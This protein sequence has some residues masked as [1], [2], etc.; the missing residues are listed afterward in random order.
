VI[1][2]VRVIILTEEKPAKAEMIDRL[3]AN[4]IRLESFEP[5]TRAKMKNRNADRKMGDRKM[6]NQQAGLH[7][8]V[9]HFSVRVGAFRSS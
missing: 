5:L 3:P 2:L 8:S 4:P 6:K 1:G 9:L 7:F